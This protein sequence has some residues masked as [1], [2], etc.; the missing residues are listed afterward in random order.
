MALSALWYWTIFRDTRDCAR[1]KFRNTRH[2]ARD[3]VNK[4]QPDFTTATAA[5][6]RNGERR[7][8]SEEHLVY[9]TGNGISDTS[10]PSP[11]PLYTLPSL[12]L[13]HS[14]PTTHTSLPLPSSP[15]GSMFVSEVQRDELSDV[16]VFGV[17]MAAY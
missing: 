6:D 8:F 14:H 3:K 9:I 16:M 11:Y 15:R 10:A 12:P 2:C 13:P 5:Q 1:D 7:Q 4:V 17:V